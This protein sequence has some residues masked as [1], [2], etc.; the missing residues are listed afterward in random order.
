MNEIPKS[1]KMHPAAK[2]CC[3]WQEPAIWINVAKTDVVWTN[4]PVTVAI[5]YRRSQEP[6]FKF[7]Q[8]QLSITSSKC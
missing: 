4:V 8:N 3:G 6:S 7:C 2:K 5:S 1:A